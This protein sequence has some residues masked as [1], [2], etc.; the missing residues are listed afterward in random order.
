MY[1]SVKKAGKIPGGVVVKPVIKGLPGVSKQP[2]VQIGYWLL[3]L[4]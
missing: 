4:K 3:S 2:E 1:S